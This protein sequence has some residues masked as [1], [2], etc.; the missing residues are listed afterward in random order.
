[1]DEAYA[2]MQR[3]RSYPIE[4]SG[5]ATVSLPDAAT[6]SSSPL[7]FTSRPHVEGRPRLF[8]VRESLV[9][10]I[11]A[12]AQEMKARGW[13]LLIEDGYRTREMQCGLARAPGVLNV[14]AERVVWERDG[15]DV[16]P[17]DVLKRVAAL[18]ANWPRTATHMSA[19]AVDISVVDEATGVEIDRG[20]PYLAL[21]Q[22]TPML[23]PFISP[24]AA[25]NRAAISEIMARHGFVA[26]PYEFWHYSQGDTFANFIGKSDQ[27]ARFGPVKVDARSG[28]TVPLDDLDAE[29]NPVSEVAD[30]VKQALEE[31]S[32]RQ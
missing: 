2:F 13:I 29:L 1:M 22:V 4:E 10:P 3:V 11:L 5:E 31:I 6:E 16:S 15:G 32:A 17:E 19:S 20:A 7:A 28:R 30:L 26:Y 9:E 12:A 25:E 8:L 18:C 21:A 14:V 27:P 23:S 24:E